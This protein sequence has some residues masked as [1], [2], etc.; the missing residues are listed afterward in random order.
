MTLENKRER[1]LVF[2]ATYN[3]ISAIKTE[4]IFILK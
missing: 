2:S 3:T 1:V 4:I